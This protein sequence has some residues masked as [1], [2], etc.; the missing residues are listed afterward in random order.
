MMRR[1]YGQL[2]AA[3]EEDVARSLPVPASAPALAPHEVDLD[4]ELDDAAQ[5]CF[6]LRV[7]SVSFCIHYGVIA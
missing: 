5:V 6:R 2:R 4:Q 1:L 3:A 7:V